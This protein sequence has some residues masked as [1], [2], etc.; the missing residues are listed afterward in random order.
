MS[1]KEGTRR[2]ALLVG[3]VGAIAG[4]IAS[5]AILGDAMEARPRYKAFERLVTS[6]AVQ[7]ERRY[8][9]SLYP[10]ADAVPDSANFATDFSTAPKLP[11]L[12]QGTVLRPIS[13]PPGF[14]PL[15]PEA[16]ASEA[17]KE[18]IKSVLW[19]KKLEIQSIEMYDGDV[20]IASQGPGLWPYL[21]GITLP[22]LGFVVPWGAIR[23]LAW[24]GFGFVEVPR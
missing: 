3:A 9:F 12:P 13:P 18:G 5:Y 22:I 23:C 1:F 10:S 21:F 19:N 17:S 4:G 2:L 16:V 11:P 20:V 15:V 8:L 24:V 7:Q 6:D 14:V